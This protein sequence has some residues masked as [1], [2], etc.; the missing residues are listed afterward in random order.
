[1]FAAIIATWTHHECCVPGTKGNFWSLRCFSSALRC[2]SLEFMEIWTYAGKNRLLQFFIN[3]QPS[4]HNSASIWTAE[5]L[6]ERG[7][8]NNDLQRETI[9]FLIASVI[10]SILK[11]FNWKSLNSWGIFPYFLCFV[12]LF[13][14]SLFTLEC[15]CT[16]HQVVSY[17]SLITFRV[18]L[19][20]TFFFIYTSVL[21]ITLLSAPL[22]LNG[23]F[24]PSHSTRTEV[25]NFSE[26]PFLSGG[27]PS[28]SS[29]KIKM[30]FFKQSDLMVIFC[31]ACDFLIRKA[32]NLARRVAKKG[33]LVRLH[34]F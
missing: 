15:R 8:R 12:P 9:R 27:M 31:S 7:R 32:L 22:I 24:P 3:D 10:E 17:V 5:W 14:A 30:D 29:I 20:D 16:K 25:K 4:K 33:L 13:P 2:V 21:F 11:L 18:S 1:M 34:P 26:K 23:N 19:S 6:N 28:R